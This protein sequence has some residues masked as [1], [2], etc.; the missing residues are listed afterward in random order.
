MY[1]IILLWLFILLLIGILLKQL[2]VKKNYTICFLISVVIILFVL[3]MNS[4]IDAALEGCKL[5][6]KAIIPT[7]LP[8]CVICNLLIC[9]DGINL[10]SKII[11]PILCKPLGLSKGCSFPIAASFLC[12]YPLGA[13]YTTDV[14]EAGYINYSE[15]KQVANVASNAGPIFLLGAVGSAMLGSTFYGYLL[16]IANYI[17]AI[18]IGFL[19]KQRNSPNN[20]TSNK[21]PSSPKIIFGDAMRTSVE[22]AINTTLNVA[23]YV[24]LF[25]VIISIVKNNE[26]VTLIINDIESVVNLPTNSLYGL[27]LGSI[28]ITN[29]TKIISELSLTLPLKLG[30]ISFLCSFSGLS[31]IAQV[32]SFFANHKLPMKNY[33]AKKFLQGILSFLLTYTITSLVLPNSI[34]TSTIPTTIKLGS[35]YNFIIPIIIFL[36]ISLLYSIIKTMYKKNSY[37]YNNKSS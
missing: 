7:I 13:K 19:F 34:V 33:I 5:V 37:F 35:Y 31:I 23:A 22:N 12:G 9:Y 14:Y 29:G 6:V 26:Y 18:L 16:L 25:S 2:K 27:L 15:F 11:G 8:F 10:Y 1:I 4:C 20:C 36:L 32:S 17:S 3:N 28:E 24:I 30:I 21:K